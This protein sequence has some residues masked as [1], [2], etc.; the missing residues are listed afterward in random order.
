[1]K[2]CINHATENSQFP[3]EKNDS[4]QNISGGE[5][6]AAFFLFFLFSLALFF[7]LN[8]TQVITS[9][10]SDLST[11]VD[12]GVAFGLLLLARLCTSQFEGS[13]ILSNFAAS[14]NRL[15]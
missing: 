7:F 14:L 1:M 5:G 13:M 8:L 11:A 4:R 3:D 15:P 12:C 6:L 2:D 9:A 10:C